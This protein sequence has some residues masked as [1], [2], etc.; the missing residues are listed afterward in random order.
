V[1]TERVPGRLADRYELERRVR[2]RPSGEIWMATDLLLVRRVAIELVDGS[3]GADPAFVERFTADRRRLAALVDPHIAH[4]LDTGEH[5]D[6]AYLVREWIRGETLADRLDREG[7]LPLPEA[8]AVARDVLFGCAALHAKG[9][10][11]LAI[12]PEAVL[13]TD[14]RAL[15]TGC[16][17]P[18]ALFATRSVAEATELLDLPEGL[19]PPEVIDGRA[20]E[21][22]DVHLVGRLLETMLGSSKELSRE[23]ARARAPD[24]ADRPTASELAERLRAFAPERPG[25]RPLETVASPGGRSRR[26]WLRTWLAVP[27][28]V[29]LL[30]ALA[31][32]IGLWLGAL[33]LGGPLGVRPPVDRPAA[34][35]ASALLPVAGAVIVD[36]PPG[37]GVENDDALPNAYDGD[38]DTVWSSS[39]Y[40]DGVMHKD[41]VGISFDLGA[42][43]VVTGF[44]LQTPYPGWTFQVAVGDDRSA[45]VPRD[46]ETFTSSPDDRIQISPTRGRYV[47]LWI[48]SVVATDDGNRA[49][50]AEFHAVGH[51]A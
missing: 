47:L 4:L 11:H 2:V 43:R 36:P 28:I 6:I 42:E 35:P 9:L 51:D 1:R 39:N 8:A 49:E 45:L 20:E 40:Y 34:S 23:I 32:V 33:E 13:L 24:P 3:L 37:D 15:L 16:P 10:L 46:S 21:R 31:T 5:G 7:A 50:V 27:I 18:A 30:A 22:S 25:A 41:G 12:T 17:L 48:T 19:V 38:R 29:A 14:D 26:G 44:R